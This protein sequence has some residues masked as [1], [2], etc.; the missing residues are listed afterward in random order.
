MVGR[1]HEIVRDPVTVTTI[2]AVPGAI[3]AWGL[4]Y[5]SLFLV[6]TACNGWEKTK[7]RVALLNIATGAVHIA[8]MIVWGYLVGR[9]EVG[10][11][12]SLALTF[13]Y[14]AAGMTNWFHTFMAPLKK[15]WRKTILP[16]VVPMLILAV[17]V[18]A[19]QPSSIP[20]PINLTM[21]RHSRHWH[22]LQRVS[23]G[24]YYYFTFL[25]RHS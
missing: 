3:C 15:R 7:G 11:M 5:F 10:Q 1:T 19:H 8:D 22:R 20:P 21:A 24:T 6:S 25:Q 2:W 16:T 18:S 17:I 13:A 23:S 9:N 12:G 4:F 14:Y